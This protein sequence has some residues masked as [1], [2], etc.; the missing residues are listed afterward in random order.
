[1]KR[2][3]LIGVISLLCACPHPDRRYPIS[4]PSDSSRLTTGAGTSKPADVTVISPDMPISPK[5]ISKAP[6]ETP[7]DI[8]KVINGLNGQLHD[9]FFD[10][11]RADVRPDAVAA[12]QQDAN[13]LL[14]MLSDFP[15]L[16]VIIEGHCDERGSAEY[17]LAL[18]DRRASRAAEFLRGF[19]LPVPSSEMISYGK[20][21]PQCT[22]SV[23]SC[24]R[25]NRR[26]HLVVRQ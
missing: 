26:A 20:E 19:G 24:W 10:Y 3:Y 12:L 9:A 4:P 15:Q 22:E 21:A 11:D 14:P 13:L 5:P 7:V 18:G 23:E 25:R 8:A 16:R 1:M 6:E 2:I 17:N